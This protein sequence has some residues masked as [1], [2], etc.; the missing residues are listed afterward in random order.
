MEQSQNLPVQG[1]V[2]NKSSSA[3]S[4]RP[5]SSTKGPL[6]IDDPRLSSDRSRH[7]SPRSPAPPGRSPLAPPR[8]FAYL[9]K[10]EIYHPLNAAQTI[11]ASFR[12]SAQQPPPG[13]PI[14]DLL[15]QGHFRA[16]AIAA[17]HA[18]TGT[19]PEGEGGGHAPAPTDHARIFDLLYTRLSCLTLID[20]TQ[21]AAQEAR[22]LEDINSALYTDEISGL[23]LMPWDLR[24]LVVRLQAMGFGDPRRAVMSYY[25]MAREARGRIAE[26]MA[27]HDNSASEMWKARLSELGIKVA[28]AL[29]EMDDL[30]GA[31]AQLA[32]LRDRGDGKSAMS[33]ALLW[34]QLG[35]TDA[36]RRCVR[37]GEAGDKTISALCDMADGDYE[38]ALTVWRGLAAEE[39]GET[40]GDEMV[41]INL[42][43][44]LLYTGKMEE[45]RVVLEGLIESGYSSHTLLFNIA[46]I[47]ELCTDRSRSLKAKLAEKMAGM[48]ATT[49]GW[50]KSNADFKL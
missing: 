23:H 6:D 4:S 9:L 20:A 7:Q 15:A 18:L 34:L 45:G 27:V 47:Y 24:L 31:A 17:V 38:A 19:G 26:A 29:V 5:R 28:G 11:P 32:S 13:T 30:P 44:C 22:A 35:D 21:T 49:R 48:E 25:D 39:E 16:A 33:K 12:S 36:A 42:A 41:A 50:E 43:V 37:Q 46:T 3:R 40:A 2:R 10:P 1:H 14:P 8:D